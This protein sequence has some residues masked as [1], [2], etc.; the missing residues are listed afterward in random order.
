MALAGEA[1]E[2]QAS[3][4]TSAS[5]CTVSSPIRLLRTST[6]EWPSKCGVVK[7]GEAGSWTS[8]CL[9]DSDATQNTITSG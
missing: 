1:R 9:S 2:S 8:A 5:S 4:T 6:D 7:N 3:W